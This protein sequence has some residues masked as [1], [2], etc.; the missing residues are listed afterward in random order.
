[1]KI[2]KVLFVVLMITSAGLTRPGAAQTA[3]AAA[4]PD[5]GRLEN[6]II[7]YKTHF[8]IGYSSTVHDVVHEYRTEMA[9][10]VLEA[11]E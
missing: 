3:A 10:R 6:V 2:L 9:D 5:K 8:D 4:S 11:I 1:M 7:V